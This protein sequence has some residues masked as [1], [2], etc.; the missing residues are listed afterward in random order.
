[1]SSPLIKQTFRL[2]VPTQAA[3]MQWL[4]WKHWL[5]PKALLLLL[6]GSSV[7]I[8]DDRSLPHLD[9]IRR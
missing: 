6:S 7:S 2:L 1:M 5:L 8:V 3:E 4:P 9:R